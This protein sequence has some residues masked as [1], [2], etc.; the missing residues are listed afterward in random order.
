MRVK[1]SRDIN[2]NK[3]VKIIGNK[4]IRGFS[5]QTSGNLPNSHRDNQPDISE[6]NGWIKKHGTTR[7]KELFG[8]N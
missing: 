8:W 2:G 6:I 4:G 5:I 7:Q 3:T 1:M